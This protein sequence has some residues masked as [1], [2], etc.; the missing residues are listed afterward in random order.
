MVKKKIKKFYNSVSIHE[1]MLDF[2]GEE[3]EKHESFIWVIAI[4]SFAVLIS[5]GV[6]LLIKGDSLKD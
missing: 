4:V 2:V 6:F 5:A 1:K 3:T